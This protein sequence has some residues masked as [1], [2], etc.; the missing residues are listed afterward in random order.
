MA[1]SEHVGTNLQLEG[2]N[3]DKINLYNLIIDNNSVF[4]CFKS[5]QCIDYVHL[6]ISKFSP[7]RSASCNDNKVELH[8]PFCQL[9]SEYFPQTAFNPVSNYSVSDFSAHSKTEPAIW[10]LAAQSIYNKKF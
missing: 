6:Q 9:L 10:Q 1:Y 2:R 5:G 4:I 7:G 3:G 8:A